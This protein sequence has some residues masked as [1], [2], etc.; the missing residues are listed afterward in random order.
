[1]VENSTGYHKRG[2]GSVVLSFAF[3]R[4]LIAS[5][6]SLS[7]LFSCASVPEQTYMEKNKLS[8][9]NKVSV[10]VS[11]AELDVKYSRETGMSIGTSASIAF[12]PLFGLAVMAAEGAGTCRKCQKQYGIALFRQIAGELFS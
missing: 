6:I 5:V 12:F 8:K 7:L 10:K 1:M 3:I 4:H 9:F 2:I 11:T